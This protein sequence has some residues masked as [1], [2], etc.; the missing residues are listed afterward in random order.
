MTD[1]DDLK[2]RIKHHK[3]ND[4]GIALIT[5]MRIRA[6]GWA[7]DIRNSVPEGREQALALTKLEECLFWCNA[8]IARHPDNWAEDQESD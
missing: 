8:G 3:P 2:N 5:D 6:L 4:D 1:I 7:I